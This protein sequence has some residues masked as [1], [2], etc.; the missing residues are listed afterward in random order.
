MPVTTTDPASAASAL[1]AHVR[2]IVHWHFSPET[3]FPYWL[4]RAAELDFDP[5]RDVTQFD[6]PSQFSHFDD[7]VLSKEDPVRFIHQAFADR[8]YNVFETGGTTGMPKQRIGRED[9]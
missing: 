8:P 4:E 6:D 3:G 2:D 9:Y 7:E 1:D 5:R